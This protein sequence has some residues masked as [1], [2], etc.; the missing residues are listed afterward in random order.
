[1]R[2][3]RHNVLLL[4]AFCAFAA[5][6]PASVLIVVN[7]NTPPEAGTD[8]VG[9]GQF[10]ANHYAEARGIPAGNIVH[11]RT[12]MACC[13]SDPRHWDSWHISWERFVSDV[14]GPI[15]S[16]LETTQLRNKI[17][18]IVPTYGVPSHISKVGPYE[19]LSVDAFLAAI[20]SPAADTYGS[21]NPVYDPDPRSDLGHWSNADVRLPFYAVVR[22]DGPSALIAAGLVDKA[23]AGEAGI[24][25]TSGVGYF[26]FRN[27]NA[28]AGAYYKVDQ[29]VQRG[30]DLCVA[31]LMNCSFNDQLQTGDMI[32]TA[33]NTLW[34][35]GWYSGPN[36]RD[37]YTF[38]PG[39]VG[40]QMTSY[41]ANAIRSPIAGG[42]VPLWLG[43]GI[44]ATW[45]ATGEPFTAGYASGDNLLNHLWNGYSYGESAYIAN[46]Y[47]GWMMVFVGDPLYTPVFNDTPPAESGSQIATEP[48]PA[49]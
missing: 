32:T 38:V 30:Y 16:Y 8:G 14:R 17:K 33:P 20:Y 45:G 47:L 24:G 3:F 37:V 13:D 2:R 46:P 48:D 43:K 21:P 25:R 49:P 44:T 11:I 5:D 31:A 34:A 1:M 40:A 12:S 18:Y 36:V 26:D 29:S 28:D 42:W 10:V 6:D 41:T 15:Q 39:A 27:L 4:F 9:A 35:W 23:K 22:L 7:D 19:S